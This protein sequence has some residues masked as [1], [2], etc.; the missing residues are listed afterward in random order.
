MVL[1][2]AIVLAAHLLLMNIAASGPLASVIIQFARK[3]DEQATRRLGQKVAGAS[4]ACFLL[5]AVFGVLGGWLMW[6]GGEARYFESLG[7]F[8]SKIFFGL[9]ELG[10]YVLCLGAYI[11]W[12][13]LRPPKSTGGNIALALVGLAAATNLL[14]H[15]P[16]LMTAVAHVAAT[17]PAGEAYDASAFR[18]L[19]FSAPVMSRWLHVWMA[20]FAT[21]GLF[22][23]WYA[24]RLQR[25]RENTP[26]VLQRA[27]AW[28]G[29]TAL[30]VTL[31]QL[32][33]GMWLLVSS[34]QVEQDRLM[35]GELLPALFL[36]TSVV[37]ALA[38]MH[39]LAAIALSGGAPRNVTIAALLLVATITLM[40][41]TLL[42]AR[43]DAFRS[44]I[45]S[46]LHIPATQCCMIDDAETRAAECLA[47]VTHH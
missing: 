29:R 7:R 14:W 11:G 40:S 42:L 5:G 36:L 38:L 31:C 45:L 47:E 6:L 32:P 9:W 4:L 46:P 8:P 24:H 23:S 20:S 41:A 34:R 16:S 19:M 28:G 43:G 3:D 2:Q 25:E 15:F 10:F 37:L 22:V 17:E 12:W 35:G 18:T 21:T 1:L 26:N 44:A 33:I 39:Q 13:K 30:V 27:S